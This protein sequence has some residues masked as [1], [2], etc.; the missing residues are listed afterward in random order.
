MGFGPVAPEHAVDWTPADRRRRATRR[1]SAPSASTRGSRA[2]SSR[3]R[4]RSPAQRRAPTTRRW[5]TATCSAAR[6]SGSRRARRS[7]AASACRA[8]S[9]EQIGSSTLAGETPLWLYIL[10]EAE[11]LHDGDRLG[12]VGGRIVGEVLV[13]II[14]ADPES[15]RSV[16]PGWT[17][18]LPG[19]AR[20]RL[21]AG[22]HPGAGRLTRGGRLRRLRYDWPS[23]PS[24]MVLHTPS[25]ASDRCL[26]AGRC[27]ARAGSESRG[28]AEQRQ[29]VAARDRFDQAQDLLK[30]KLPKQAYGTNPIVL[31][32]AKG[33]LTDSANSKAVND[34]RRVAEEGTRRRPGGQPALRARERRHSA[35]TRRSDTSR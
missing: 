23:L 9:A 24:R 8:L 12:P 19:P 11:V 1:R 14:D 34:D 6:P 33:K 7:R 16:D 13:G 26:G 27:G 2:R 10:K 31:E 21:R 32:A 20:R 15:F 17:P 35:R 22:R 4:R 29:P 25:L 3:C 28:R 5:P 18:T 30:S